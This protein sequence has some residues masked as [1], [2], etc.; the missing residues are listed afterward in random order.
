MEVKVHFD[1]KIV[2]HERM[3]GLLGYIGEALGLSLA[4]WQIPQPKQPRRHDFEQWPV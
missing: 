4:R 2:H 3:Q 1:E